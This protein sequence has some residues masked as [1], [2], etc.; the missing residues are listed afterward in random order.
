MVLWRLTRPSRTNTKK[1][2]PFHHQFSSVIQSCLT[3]CNQM[4]CYML[5]FPVHHQ[6]L[7]LTQ[8]HV[9]FGG[10]AIQLSHPLSSPSPPTFNLPQHQGLFK[11]VSSSHQV[12]KVLQFQLQHQSFQWKSGLI[13]FTM[14][15]LDLIAV[16]GTLRSLLQHHS[17]KAPILQCLDFFHHRGLE[18]KSRKS[19][20]TWSNRQ[21]WPW[22]TKWSWA[23][24]NRVL[25][26]EHTGH[27]KH[28]LPTM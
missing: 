20:S 14:D 16:Q 3:L 15:W 17:S 27:D 18:C 6:F 28:P 10:D 19:K 9:P 26:R 22:S 7:E 8:T 21:A 24:A 12:A 11:W 4:D 13:S 2:C 25:Q 1:R 5:G 23:D